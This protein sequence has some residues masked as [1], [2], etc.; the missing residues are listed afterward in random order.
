[1]KYRKSYIQIGIVVII[2]V[3]FWLIPKDYLGEKY[4]ICL[5]R[6]VTGHQCL[7]CG[8]TRAIWS[9]LHFRF[10]EA[11]EYNWKVVIVLPILVLGLIQ[12]SLIKMGI[13]LRKKGFARYFRL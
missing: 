1:M 8:M 9:I 12:W 10:H 2:A 7:G 11:L 3:L 5:F 13:V 4:P 6:L